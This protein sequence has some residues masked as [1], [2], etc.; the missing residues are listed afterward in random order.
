MKPSRVRSIRGDS[1]PTPGAFLLRTVPQS[2]PVLPYQSR[3]MMCERIPQVA[4]QASE[5]NGRGLR[6]S[7]AEDDGRKSPTDSGGPWRSSC[8]T[9]AKACRPTYE[10]GAAPLARRK[11]SGART[12]ARGPGA[13]AVRSVLACMWVR[14]RTHM[15]TQWPRSVRWAAAIVRRWRR[16]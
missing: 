16:G 9:C 15:P 5:S 11:G 7:V 13:T 14:A 8:S 10:Q 6:K 1:E 4:R 3:R 2:G 12:R